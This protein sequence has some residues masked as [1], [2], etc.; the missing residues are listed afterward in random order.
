MIK[1]NE[2]NIKKAKQYY[3]D[4]IIKYIKA[5]HSNI[6][7]EF[8][9]YSCDKMIKDK[10]DKNKFNL[11]KCYKDFRKTDI[12]YEFAELF[13]IKTCP[14]CNENFAYTRESDKKVQFQFDH[15]LPQKDYPQFA[16]NFYN[17]IPSCSYCNQIKNTKK[18]HIIYPIE[19]S[20]DD[21][22]KFEII[23]LN[24]SIKNKNDFNIDF[25]EKTNGKKELLDKA[26]NSIKI[27]KLI[28]RYH[29]HKDIALEII[30]RKFLYTEEFTEEIKRKLCNSGFD[31]DIDRII[32]ANYTSKYDINNR[33]FSKLTR[34]IL[35]I[36]KK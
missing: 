16:M 3:K 35:N 20:F 10:K 31:C 32:Y 27:F 7:D 9:L 6:A 17:L 36:F 2:T 23:P 8:L 5:Y 4:N 15:F 29:E 13:G 28:E 24:T 22:M 33:P 11:E 19:E 30:C 26:K 25:R 21:I 12:C 34:D 14:Y 1:I 18:G